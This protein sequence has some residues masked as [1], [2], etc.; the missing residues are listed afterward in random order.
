[1]WFSSKLGP[2][3]QFTQEQQCGKEFATVH[4][5]L[6]VLYLNPQ[7]ISPQIKEVFPS[8]PQ[9][10]NWAGSRATCIQD[11]GPALCFYVGPAYLWT[12]SSL[13]L[14]ESPPAEGPP[15][16]KLSLT[17]GISEITSDF[18]QLPRSNRDWMSVTD[19]YLHKF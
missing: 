5:K 7:N 4:L 11:S 17:S 18:Y 14:S 13:V 3:F 9:T 10:P 15:S 19:F 12:R 8:K 1:M 16:D 6:N 2:Q